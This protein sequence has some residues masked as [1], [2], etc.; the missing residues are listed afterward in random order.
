[1]VFALLLFDCVW[2]SFVLVFGLVCASVLGL[3]VGVLRWSVR[4]AV[5]L[6]L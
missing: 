2:V 3:V 1:M 5:L 4:V 6:A